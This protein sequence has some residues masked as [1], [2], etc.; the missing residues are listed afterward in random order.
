MYRFASDL[1]LDDLVGSEIQQIC[2]GPSDVQFRFG[3]GTCIAVQNRATLVRAG[4]SLCEWAAV[5]GWSNCEFQCL[6]NCTID[7]YGVLNDQLLEIRFI[8]GLALQFHDDSDHFESLQ[9]YPG[10]SVV[11]S[12]AV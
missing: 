1:R 8:G 3:S 9:I 7:G 6:F 5:G 11:D 12:I 2:V 4:E 10:G